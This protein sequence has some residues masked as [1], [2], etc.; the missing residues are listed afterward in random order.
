MTKKR[1]CIDIEV[2]STRT[3]DFGHLTGNLTK[4]VSK[5]KS[6]LSTATLQQK[7]LH[8]SFCYSRYGECNSASYIHCG[9]ILATT[10]MLTVIIVELLL[11]D[12]RTFWKHLFLFQLTGI[13]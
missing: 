3:E 4:L 6:Q 13:K 9:N 11:M 12:L 1:K 8:F 5:H 2:F 7:S 10:E